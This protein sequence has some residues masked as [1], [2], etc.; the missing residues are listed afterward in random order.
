VRE[1]KVEIE[2]GSCQ[3]NKAS[4]FSF[5][6]FEETPRLQEACR[7]IAKRLL[8]APSP[9]RRE[10]SR[11][12]AEVSKLYG[13]PQLPANAQILQAAENL[14]PAGFLQVLRRKAVRRTSGVTVIAVMTA[15]HPCPHGRCLYCPGGPEQG[16]PQ[17]YTGHEPASLRGLQNDFDPGRQVWSRIRQLRAIG[18]AVDK[19]ELIVMGGTFLSTPPSYQEDFIRGCLDALNGSPSRSLSEAKLKAER[20]E[21]R[22]VGITVETRPDWSRESHIDRMLELGVTRVELGVQTL[23]DDVYRLVGRGHAVGDVAEAARMLKDA[24]LKVCF[25]MMPN[26]PGSDWEKDLKMFQTLF[27][28]EAFKPDMLKIYPTVVLEGTG[29]HEMWRKGAY[30]PY[31]Q[32]DLVELLARVKAQLPGWVR[33]QRIQR[34]IP[35]PKTCAGVKT[36][37]LREVV[38]K[39]MAARGWRCRCI[40]CREVG[41][42]QLK[43]GLRPKPENIRLKVE[44]YPASEGEEVFLSYEDVEQDILVGFLRLRKPSPKA[45]RCEVGGGSLI[46]RELHVYGPMLPL[47]VREE[48]GW[49]HRG[50]GRSLLKAAEK[51]AVEDYGAEKIL[52]TAAL[53]VKEYYYRLGYRKEG[54]YVAKELRG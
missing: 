46:V 9:N 23:Y 17:S 52:V 20:G 38:R 11:I 1:K 30:L 18:H 51:I 25:H 21:I 40:R 41:H 24:G 29:L 27:E 12:K 37:S 54:P 15:P 53:G 16:V 28:D 3:E 42:S 50:Y 47:G 26:L 48:E 8:A 36:G 13:L 39:A 5:Q 49:Q 35:L 22:N 32:E 10:L 19:A 45:H 31:P 44:K 14:S 34:D 2:L 33:I 6:N 7:E 4:A 43:R